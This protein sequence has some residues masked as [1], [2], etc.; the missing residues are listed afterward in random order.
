[1]NG[2]EPKKVKSKLF[3]WT[4][5]IFFLLMSITNISSSFI[6]AI[7]FLLAAI[8][9]IPPIA[10]QFDKKSKT[11]MSNTVRFFVVFILLVAGSS[12]L[13]DDTIPVNNSE[14]AATTLKEESTST[15]AEAPES[16][17]TPEPEE[18][19]KSEEKVTKLEDAKYD[20]NSGSKGETVS[21]EDAKVEEP[22]D[23]DSTEEAYQKALA[24]QEPEEPEETPA[25]EETQIPGS[26]MELSESKKE[27]LI[28]IIKGY[29]GSDEVEVIYISPKDSSSTGLLQVDYYLD[30]TPS[31]DKLENDLNYILIAS[32]NIAE[33]SGIT[34][35]DV[36]VAAMLKDG[37]PLGVGNYYSST[38]KTDID[39]SA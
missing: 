6:A 30:V 20:K 25:L 2:I 3:R 29:S 27:E 7:L 17:M 18:T 31:K 8:I 9:L 5:G 26:T 24:E 19:P 10:A 37:L 4:F 28:G 21:L 38:E 22:I 23:E 39:T 36:S 13:P 14:T 35:A 11:S 33:K 34:N 1:M 32:Q 15:A 16:E 12:A